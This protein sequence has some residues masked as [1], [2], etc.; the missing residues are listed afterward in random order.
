MPLVITGIVFVA[1]GVGVGA[2]IAVRALP[3]ALIVAAVGPFLLGLAWIAAGR[4]LVNRRRRAARILSGGIAGVATIESVEQ[5]KTTMNNAPV[6]KLGLMVSI[7]GHPAYQVTVREPVELIH[8]A[9]LTPGAALAIKVDP[10]DL[11]QLE[12]DW[13]VSLR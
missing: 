7:E 13:N 6:I 5:T 12:I 1:A 4:G 8:L 3:I 11:G 2:A 9:R 10:S